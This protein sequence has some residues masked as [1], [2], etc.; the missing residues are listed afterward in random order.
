MIQCSLQQMLFNTIFISFTLTSLV[1][2]QLE[3]K[4]FFQHGNFED[5]KKS[6]QNVYKTRNIGSRFKPHRLFTTDEI[7]DEAESFVEDEIQ[8]LDSD[9][10]PMR[11][12][13]LVA[14]DLDIEKDGE[15][16]QNL[17]GTGR[18]WRAIIQ[19]PGAYTISLRFSSFHLP[20][21]AELYIIGPN[22]SLQIIFED[23]N[24]A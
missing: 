9:L 15:W 18:V 8:F 13:R 3:S 6:L 12:G 5:V 10:K 21:Q 17:E 22:V 20:D 2:T 16:I 1:W 24:Q 23:V 11:I 7:A 14:M 4:G 19:S